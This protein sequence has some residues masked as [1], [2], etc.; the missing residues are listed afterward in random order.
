MNGIH[1]A[2]GRAVLLL[3]TAST[4]AIGVAHAQPSSAAQAGAGGI[5][6]PASPRAKA[7]EREAV[8]GNEEIIVTGVGKATSARKANVAY[9]VLT[10]EDMTKFT[11]ISADDM[12]RD[13]PG[14][15][16]ESND[17]VARNEVFTRGMTIG[18][19]ANT[20]GYFW[21]TILE[22]GLPVVPFKFSGFQDGYFYRADISTSR[23]ESVRGGSSATSVSTSVG[24][25]FNYITGPV[26]AGGTLQARLGL[27]GD[28][29]HLSWKQI[30]GQ[31]G[32]TNKAGDFGVGISGFY[33]T[34]NGQVNPGYDINKGGQVRLR[35]TKEYATDNGSGM[36]V[37]GFKHLDDVNGE[38]TAFQQPTY[39]YLNSTE[40]PG[41]G[42]DANLWLKGGKQT[43]PNYFKPG[44]HLLDPSA[45]F[46]YKQDAASF[47]WSHSTDNGWNVSTALRLQKSTYRGQGFKT[48]TPVSL[49]VSA[50]ERERYGLNINN[51]DRTP[52]YYEFRDANGSLVARVANNVNGSQLG[53]NYRT[54][55]A[56]PRVTATTFQSNSLCVTYNSLP[57]RDLDV[58]GGVVTGSAPNASGDY[59]TATLPVG[60]SSQD[61]VLR[62][63]VEDTY[64]W[65]KDIMFNLAVGHET[66]RFAFNAG[67]YFA[68]S[69]QSNNAW[70]NG[71]GLSAWADGQVENLNV[72]YVTQGGTT[73]QLTDPG[74]WG[75]YGTGL[76][77]TVTQKAKITE[78][79]PRAELRWS[80]NSH[81][82]FNA[83]LKYDQ[84]YARTDS[85]TYDTRNS[86]ATSLSNGGLDGNPLTV[87]DNLYSVITPAKMISAKRSIGVFNY[88]VALG[89]NIN[90]DHKFYIRY[91]DGKQPAM[92]IVQRYTTAATL[93][94]PLGPT[95]YV[96][97]YEIAYTFNLPR[98]NG[99]LTYFKQNFAVNDYP[100]AI[101]TDNVTTYLL[102]ENFNKYF[103]RGIEAWAKVRVTRGLEW[104]PSVTFL[105]GRTQA[106]YNWLN[107][108]ANGL[109][110][111]DDVLRVDSG[112]LARSPKWTI[113]NVLSYRLGDVR[114]NLRHRW[115][116]ER[117]LSTNA[118]DQ[119]ILPKQD[120]L[121][122]SIEYQPQRTTRI[123]FDVRNVMNKQYIS[124][125]DPVLGTNL[126]S[127]IQSYDVTQQ[128]PDSLFL[129]RRNAPRSMWLTIRQDF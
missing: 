28:D 78:I 5:R 90:P 117:R 21:T 50:A 125:Y 4:A 89:Y 10:E 71:Q 49:G 93:V 67:V 52:G 68:H 84:F 35:A 37:M 17:G 33:R 126:P 81:W 69:R 64:R 29:L 22:D 25:T 70:A 13:M 48:D 102:P 88:S 1:R 104:N 24:A 54:G 114:L 36:F 112:G 51:L 97:G 66:Q 100:T 95:A 113:S 106:A 75:Y 39:G 129:L 79:A 63:R 6:T 27:E 32:W 121:D 60:S 16:V 82:D 12:L 15:V 8:Q 111:A 18:T 76:F 116:S 57:N 3:A 74:G 128:L 73:Y 59:T 83:S 91:T 122:A 123:I 119:R 124:A 45:G 14:V 105:N 26:K 58:R 61:L 47:N 109:G 23:V 86:G 77:A 53:T 99:A 85:T 44:S 110:A 40:I 87:Y 42:R 94:R 103:T 120:N 92:G 19:G 2:A 72:S 30:D 38:L 65:S 9:S 56:C 108:G 20:S 98:V 62:T 55:A 43:V 96:K 80:P 11:P 31:Y 115:M 118:L 34:S 101:D 7:P 107:I 46:R 41:F 127:G